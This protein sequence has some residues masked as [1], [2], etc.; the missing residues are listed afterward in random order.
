MK[1]KLFYSL[2]S[3][4]I[5]NLRLFIILM[6]LFYLLGNNICFT[7]AISVCLIIGATPDHACS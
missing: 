6:G 1:T 5:Y 2:V 4:S 7:A 3:N